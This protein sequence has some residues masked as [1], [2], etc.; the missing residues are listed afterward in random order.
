M[1][2]SLK[3]FKSK[4]FKVFSV[5]L[6]VAIIFVIAYVIFYKTRPKA[7]TFKITPNQVV[8][9]KTKPVTDWSLSIAK[10]DIQ[11]PIILNVDGADK[12]AYFKSLQSGVA[13]MKGTAKPGEGN[14]VIF[15]HSNF[16]E[17]DPGK[18]KTVF[19]HLDQLVIGDEIQIVSKE[20]ALIY[21]VS[22]T[23]MVDA[24]DVSVAQPT[25]NKQLTLITCWPPGTINQRLIVIADLK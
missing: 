10:L 3:I 8:A 15:G 5:I 18:F 20:Q 11:A 2:L 22:K 19:A 1:F 24:T 21:I 9:T 6:I 23:E 4:I 25:E 14:T 17:D 13:Q 12:D 7:D 16:Y